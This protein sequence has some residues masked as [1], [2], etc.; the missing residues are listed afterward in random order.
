MRLRD[1][2]IE[3]RVSFLHENSYLFL[4]QFK[5]PIRESV[6]PGFRSGWQNRS[7]LVAAKVEPVLEA[8]SEAA[9]WARQ[10]VVQGASRSD[11]RCVEAHIYGTFN[12]DSVASVEFAGPGSSREEKNDIDCIKEFVARRNSGGGTP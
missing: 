5:V 4:D 12:A 10:L 1:L 11:D 2:A 8:G 3:Q 9:D 7:Q 6:P